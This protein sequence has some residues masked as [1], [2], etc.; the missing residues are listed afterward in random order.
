MHSPRVLI[1]RPDHIG[2][3]LLTSPAIEVLRRE[4]PDA[5]ITMMVGPW[6]EDVA[7]RDPLVDEVA[8]CRF[9]GFTREA[10]PSLFQPYRLLFSAARSLGEREY[11]AALIMRFDHWWGAWLAAAAG[12]PVR[13]GSCVPECR[14][15]LTHV[16]EP[17]E[18][19][20]WTSKSISVAIRLL[21][22]WGIRDVQ[23][24][25]PRLRFPLLDSEEAAA[26]GL[27]RELP[28][29]DGCAVVAVHPGTGAASKL[30]PAEKWAALGRRLKSRGAAVLVTGSAGESALAEG[31]AAA[32]PGAVSLAGRTT[33][34]VLG[35]VFARCDLVVGVDSGPLHLA[36]AVGTPSVHLFG[37]TDPAVYGPWGDS[38]LHR[39]VTAG[40]QGSPCGR[41]DVL[42]A[43][44]NSPACMR[45]IAVDEVERTCLELLGVGKL[46][47]ARGG[48]WTPD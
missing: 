13:V 39:V 16:S 36:V 26:A 29:V 20:H 31:I 1:I 6:S 12:I 35:S 4:L 22:A 5:H 19:E 15:F 42:P 48:D 9:P 34:G 44:G 14:P 37:P 11:D 3:V 43:G 17:S 33:I 28:I 18:G 10:P 40:V 27:W 2:D 47:S 46:G 38:R 7:R 25:A 30:W 41:L 24:D 21:D 32:I 8:V 45:A 23:R